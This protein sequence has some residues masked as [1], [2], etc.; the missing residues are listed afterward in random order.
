[1]P[2]PIKKICR[3]N[4]ANEIIKPEVLNHNHH[5]AY[6]KRV[7]CKNLAV[8]AFLREGYYELWQ[9]HPAIA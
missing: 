4:G 1:M 3:K 7:K 6:A 2:P 5:A 8:R 9:H